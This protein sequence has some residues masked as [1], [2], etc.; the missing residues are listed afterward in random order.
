MLYEDAYKDYSYSY[1]ENIIRNGKVIVIRQFCFKG[2][3]SPRG[4]NTA[5]SSRFLLRNIYIEWL[6]LLGDTDPTTLVEKHSPSANIKYT[7]I[8]FILHDSKEYFL[9]KIPIL[10]SIKLLCNTCIFVFMD[11]ILRS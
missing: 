11:Y 7:S 9:L 3:F 1:T 8:E 2:L 6:L 5:D 10:N 4:N